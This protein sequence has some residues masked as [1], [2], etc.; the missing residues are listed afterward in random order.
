LFSGSALPAQP[1]SPF[2][3]DPTTE[4][5]Y[6]VGIHDE[7]T[8]YRLHKDGSKYLFLETST[9]QWL[10]LMPKY[11][12]IV[13]ASDY[14]ILSYRL[15][16]SF[17]QLIYSCDSLDNC[18]EVAGLAADDETGDVY[19]LIQHPNATKSLFG[20]N[21]DVRTPYLIASSTDFPPIRQLLVAGEKLAFI[22]KT[23]Q[24]G[25]CDKKLGSL[26]FNLV[27]NGVSL[28]VPSANV[29]PTNALN[30]SGNIAFEDDLRTN[31]TWSIDPA[32]RKG[33]IIYK[34]SMYKEKFG[35]ERF[36]DFSV[37]QSYTMNSELLDEWSSKQKFDVQIDAISAWNIV[38][39]N[40]TGL[41][42]P[43]K[44]PSSV[45]NLKIY[46]TQQVGNYRRFF[47]T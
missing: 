40:R 22:T 41:F 12:V 31:L 38:S 8:L 37:E 34:I 23:G 26:N 17:D 36:V 5:L 2:A 42:A 27:L 1:E 24:M 44:P 21:Q 11:S 28:L 19:F 15:T 13:I 43:T 47:F 29:T 3:V 46:A 10:A 45:R 35:D 20:L 6:V 32:P 14:T 30:F 33:E 16:S 18:G 39:R 7:N 9:I 4:S 25:V